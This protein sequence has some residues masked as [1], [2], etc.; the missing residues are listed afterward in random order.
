MDDAMKPTKIHDSAY[1]ADEVFWENS[2]KR[3]PTINGRP[4]DFSKFNVDVNAPENKE[5]MEDA[6]KSWKAE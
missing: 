5:F 6:S 2:Y 3:L 4:I 1:A